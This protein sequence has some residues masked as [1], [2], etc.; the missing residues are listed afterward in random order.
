MKKLIRW[1][2]RKFGYRIIRESHS[3]KP[4]FGLATF[5]AMLRG[6]GFNPKQ[7]IDVGANR[8]S[9][10]R[11]AVEFFPD[12]HYILL[13]PQDHLKID[14]HDLVQHGYNITWINAGAGDKK[15]NLPF[16]VSCRDDSSSFVSQVS[17]DK[18]SSDVLV[19]V[20]TLNEVVS[21]RGG[22]TPEMVKIDAE[23]FDLHVLA[24][25]S[26]LLGRTEIFLVEAVIC[27]PVY[28]NTLARVVTWMDDAG[29]RLIDITDINRSVKHGVLWLCELA[30]LRKDSRLLDS[31]TTYE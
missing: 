20:T 4:K 25:A 19:T 3:A 2:L 28:E 10:T 31:A 26:D 8:G 6:F 9:W 16:T 12:A 22:I 15:G 27:A 14:I 21:S 11:K 30:F 29:Y 17:A 1:S 13:E 24:G 18:E 7:I 5:F 23:G